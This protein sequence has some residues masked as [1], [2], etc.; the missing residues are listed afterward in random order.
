MSLPTRVGPAD[1]GEV[2]E[3]ATMEGCAFDEEVF[4]VDFDGAGLEGVVIPLTVQ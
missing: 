3:L 1:F 4:I 2:E